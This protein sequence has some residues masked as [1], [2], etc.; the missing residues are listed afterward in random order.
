MLRV[1]QRFML[2]IVVVRNAALVDWLFQVSFGLFAV[3]IGTPRSY[4]LPTVI[5]N[6][7]LL[8]GTVR[9]QQ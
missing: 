1:H 2:F 4:L 8:F 7:Y 9:C 6:E 3:I 5:G